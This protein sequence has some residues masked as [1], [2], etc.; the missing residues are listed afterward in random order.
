MWSLSLWQLTAPKQL[1]DGDPVS[2][3][4]SGCFLIMYPFIPGITATPYQKGLHS[5]L[6]KLRFCSN[7]FDQFHEFGRD[8][9]FVCLA[10]WFVLLFLSP[11]GDLSNGCL[12]SLR[13]VNACRWPGGSW[14]PS[15][16]YWGAFCLLQ[17][18]VRQEFLHVVHADFWCP[19]IVH[20][21]HVPFFIINR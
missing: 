7:A 5:L 2:D 18:F 12:V 1:R 8:F 6:W 13:T 19:K 4:L 10:G 3:A 14:K 9:L 11:P 16:C 15:E 21:S 20:V 17:E